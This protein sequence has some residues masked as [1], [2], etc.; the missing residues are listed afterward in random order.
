MTTQTFKDLHREDSI[1]HRCGVTMND[2]ADA[3]VIA[4][5]MHSKPG[6]EVGL[7]VSSQL[8]LEAIA[9]GTGAVYTCQKSFRA[10][11]RGAFW[12]HHPG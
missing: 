3:R 12:L 11:C 4:D 8:P 7:T 1:S 10:E 6:V 5:L 2:S 9:M